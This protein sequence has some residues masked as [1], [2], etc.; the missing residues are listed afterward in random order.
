MVSVTEVIEQF[1]ERELIDWKLRVGLKK[2]TQ[3]SEEALRIGTEIDS[4]V[5]QQIRRK[6]YVVPRDH[7]IE[8]TW[9]NWMTFLQQHPTNFLTSITGLQTELV[10]G[11][12]IGHPDFQRRLPDGRRG[13]DDLKCATQIR[14]S[15]FAQLGGYAWLEQQVFGRPPPEWLGIIRLNKDRPGY[16]YLQ[17]TAPEDIQTAMETFLHYKAL[18]DFRATVD[19]W[20]IDAQEAEALRDV[21]ELPQS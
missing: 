10:Q 5:Q 15:H 12:L 9:A 2:A 21:L 6:T 4:L 19:K 7:L 20:R 1:P 13:I 14:P 3:I 16:D 8:Q 17:L 18:Y 11:E